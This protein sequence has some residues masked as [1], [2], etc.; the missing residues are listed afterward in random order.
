V[1]T[2]AGLKMH[3]VNHLPLRPGPDGTAG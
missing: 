2:F 1:A 3:D